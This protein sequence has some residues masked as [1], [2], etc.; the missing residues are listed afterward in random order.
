MRKFLSV[1]SVFTL[2]ISMFGVGLTTATGATK[3]SL[4]ANGQRAFAD[5]G[6][7]LQSQGREK[8]LDVF[9]LIDE[10]ASLT[11][12][13]P[14]NDRAEILS[15]NLTQLASFRK[16]V[17]VNYSVAFFAQSYSV[18]KPWSTVNSGSI[19]SD[20]RRLDNEVRSR[21]K[22]QL[23]DWLK[24]IN[25]AINELNAQHARTGGCSTLVWLTDGGIQLST[26]EK[27]ADA[28][29]Q[30]CENRFDVLRKNRVT[31]LG[32]LLKNDE[33]LNKLSADK[34]DNQLTSMSFMRPI[35]EGIGKLSDGSEQKCGANPVPANYHQGALFV[36]KDPRDLAFEFLKLPPQLEGCQ[37]TN[38]L[39][40][41]S[42]EFQ[43]ENGISN[44]QIATTSDTWNLVNPSGKSVNNQTANT[45]VLDSAG[46][47]QIRVATTN[48]GRGKWNFSGQGGNSQ[49]YLCSGLDIVIDEGVN[50]IAGK[51]GILSG[52]VVYQVS[53]EE[54]DLSV[55]DSNHPITVQ[56]IGNGKF[57]K[58]QKAD[59]APNGKWV[60]QKFV[61]AS[62]QDQSEVR[63]TLSLTTKSG[64]RLAPISISQKLDVRNLANYPTLKSDLVKLSDLNPPDRRATGI[65]TFRGSS[66]SDGKIC[67]NPDA[68]PIVVKDSVRRENSFVLNKEG[69]DVEGCAPVR[70]GE[71]ISVKLTADNSVTASSDV[72]L[73]VP[74]EYYSETEPGK[75]LVLS[76]PVAFKSHTINEDSKLWYILI[77]TA[78]GILLPL[79]LIYLLLWWTTRIAYGRQLER[80][81][82]PVAITTSGQLT[83]RDGTQLVA[84]S[85][86]F[87]GRPQQPDTRIVQDGVATLSA[88]VPKTILDEPW[89]EVTAPVGSRVITSGGVSQ[90]IK[91][92]RRFIGGK[93][94]PIVGD[95]GKVWY[96]AIKDQV[97]LNADKDKLIEG[98]LVIFNRR[99]NA[100]LNQ[101]REALARVASKPGLGTEVEKLIS[102]AKSGVKPPS[103]ES[104]ITPGATSDP[105]SQKIIGSG[106]PTGSPSLGGSGTGRSIP[107]GPPPSGG[108]TSTPRQPAPGLNPPGGPGGP[109]S[110][111]GQP[112]RGSP[113]APS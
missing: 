39:D 17:T 103:I 24:G 85:E 80:A 93:L 12:T 28:V 58:S 1:A 109:G 98:T 90:H 78:L 42:G 83:A 55:Y 18:W 73:A 74:I 36:A 32:V 3:T 57:G 37:A 111:S 68:K 72:V 112:R 62:G 2:T 29:V 8:V 63:I 106:A 65:A 97:L 54:A 53:G 77:L 91:N 33:A 43:I 45:K 26:P 10:S 61:P 49:L 5:L 9:Y 104:G 4:S 19:I 34:K 47:A 59:Q 66:N 100:N 11:D 108:P 113:G 7:C 107:G 35:V 52:K 27:T 99:N 67:F 81:E 44:F 84:D 87:I 56:Q 64:I 46:A 40:S 88:R 31:V 94:S 69:L 89:Y 105:V 15:S 50:P 70:A 23:T 14:E 41:G 30:L 16:G 13:D 71:E 92:K 110:P 82:F 51:A 22:G 96:L 21:N 48:S 79:G 38:K 75:S 20:A 102:A 6:R 60:V 25:G 101:H 76:A 86:K 95:L